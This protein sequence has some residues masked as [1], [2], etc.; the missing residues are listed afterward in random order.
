MAQVELLASLADH[1]PMRVG[2]LAEQL[3]LAPNSASELVQQLV[4]AGLARRE[5]SSSDRR[6]SMITLTDEG[7]RELHDWQRAHQRR[8][9]AALD[10]LATADRVAVVAALPGLDQLAAGLGVQGRSAWHTE[11]AETRHD[12]AGRDT[13]RERSEP[14]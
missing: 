3:R 6:V 7:L 8:I 14:G 13:D 12:Q 4:D 9:G 1:S 11:E 2:A 10:N 5:A